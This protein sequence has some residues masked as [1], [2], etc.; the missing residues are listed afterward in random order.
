VNPQ[1]VLPV[2]E[3]DAIDRVLEP[4][5]AHLEVLRERIRSC[6]EQAD[7]WDAQEGGGID[8]RNYRRLLLD[9]ERMEEETRVYIRWRMNGNVRHKEAK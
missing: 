2:W 9:A 1:W 8:A 7:I 4:L 5:V 3:L 6:Q